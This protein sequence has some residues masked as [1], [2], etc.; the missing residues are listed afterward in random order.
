[1]I[2]TII[3]ICLLSLLTACATPVPLEFHP[4]MV[5][6]S[7]RKLDAELRSIS[8]KTAPP[9]QRMGDVN[10]FRVEN[11]IG[12]QFIQTSTGTGIPITSQWEAALNDA[13]VE[14]LIFR[15]D[16]PR[17]VSLIVEIEKVEMSGLATVDYDVAA[18]YRLMD[19][20]TGV[21]A[22]SKTIESRGSAATSEAFVG[23]VRARLAFVRSVKANIKQFLAELQ[24]VML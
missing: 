10:W 17:K 7:K 3:A 23:A 14:S 11:T 6:Q 22:Y 16:A 18:R 15:D 2:R 20:E 21:D 4:D 9:N 5:Q 1:M 19:R 12:D 13:L 24:A 8:V